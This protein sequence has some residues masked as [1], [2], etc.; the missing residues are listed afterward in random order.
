MQTNGSRS[1]TAWSWR[2]TRSG[3]RRARRRRR[4]VRARPRPGL[5]RPDVGRRRRRARGA[6]HRSRPSTCAATAAPSKPDGAVRRR[7]GRRRPRDADRRARAATGRSS[8][9][10]RGAA[11]SSWSS[12]PATRRRRAAIVCVD[13]GWLEPA[14]E[15]PGLG[16]VPD[17][18][19][20]AAARGT[21]A[22]PRSRDTSAAAPRLAGDRASAARSRTSRS[23]ADGTIAPWLTFE[24]H[25]AVLRGLWEHRP[26]ERYADVAVPVLLVPA[27]GGD[28]GPTGA[29]S[30]ERSRRRRRRS[31][32]RRVHWFAGDHDLHAQHPD[33]LADV[34]HDVD[35]SRT[36]LPRVSR[37]RA[38][39]AIMGSGET[40][41]TMAKVHRALLDR[42]GAG[43]VPAAI[44]DTPYGF[45]ENADDLSA[46]TV[47][48]LRRE[49]RPRR[50]TVASYRSRGRRRRSTPRRPSPGS[51]RH[52]T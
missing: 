13:G 17:G 39:L 24:R 16:G 48:L 37:R 5:E 47:A 36:G 23:G 34:L 50:S 25:I 12:R 7:D 33:E 4:A 28:G 44:L 9:A 22:A 15:L 19:G 45:Q 40:A 14:A 51:A 3:P 35:A 26:A 30:A 8:P 2:S 21:A 42:L 38:I 11:T 52:A 20:A 27:D 6:G 43:P 32:M 1:P 31:P 18:P 46:R 41:P 29:R 49:R 10:S